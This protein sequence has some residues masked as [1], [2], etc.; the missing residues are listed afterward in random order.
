MAQYDLTPTLGGYLDRHMMIPLLE[1]LLKTDVRSL[2]INLTFL[3]L[4]SEKYPQLYDEKQILQAKLNLLEKTN[5][6]D[7]SADI[8]MKL[9]PESTP[10]SLILFLKY[11]YISASCYLKTRLHFF[12]FLQ[13]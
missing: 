11:G 5:M 7:L 6:V 2:L 13:I 12:F 9:Q 3:S 10:G 1:F 4:L 8:V